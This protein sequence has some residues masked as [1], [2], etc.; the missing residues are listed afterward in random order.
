MKT[1]F[2][3]LA[4]LSLWGCSSP[5][6]APADP[7]ITP[8]LR[9]GDAPMR[10]VAW[11][12]A[13]T[14]FIVCDMWDDH[15]CKGAARRVA[16]LAVPMNRLLKAARDRG[17]LILHAP[18]STVAFYKDTPARKRAQEAPF[19]P[20]PAPLSKDDRWGT[21]WC[22]PDKS[23]EPDLP[24]DDSD[25]GCDCPQKCTLREAWTRQIATLEIDQT[26]D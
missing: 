13:E 11:K 12:P 10:V 5:D 19:A 7:M 6:P 1:F 23:R 9:S 8:R 3:L 24:I 16:E 26:R 20:S 14:A 18:S 2:R 25:M 15:W 17:C 22:W 21:K 4:S